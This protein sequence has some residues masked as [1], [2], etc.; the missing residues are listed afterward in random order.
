M[1]TLVDVSSYPQCIFIGEFR[2]KRKGLFRSA[3]IL[4]IADVVRLHAVFAI[5]SP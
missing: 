1:L 4:Q 5:C 2:R 3:N